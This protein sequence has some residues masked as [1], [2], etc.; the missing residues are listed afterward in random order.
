MDDAVQPCL[1]PDH[2]G[3]PCELSMVSMGLVDRPDDQEILRLAAASVPVLTPC[4]VE[5]CYL[6]RGGRLVHATEDRPDDVVDLSGA[7]SVLAGEQGPVALSGRRWGWAYALCCPRGNVGYLVVSAA[8]EPAAEHRFTLARLAEETGAALSRAASYRRERARAGRLRTSNAELAELNDRLHE[9]VVELEQQRKMLVTL[10][11]VAAAGAG[12]SGIAAALH[13][14]TGHAVAVEDQFGNPLAW[15]GPDRP[16]PYPRRSPRRRAEL[17]AEAGRMSGP[18]R[19]QDR[20]IALVRSYDGVLGVLALVDPERR[21][22]RQQI[23]ALEHAAAV[24]AIELAHQRDLAEAELRHRGDLIGDLL[25]GAQTESALSRAAA[26]GHD[27]HGPHQVLVLRWPA[28]DEQSVVLAVER[29][30]RLSDVDALVARRSGVVVMVAARPASWGRQNHWSEFHHAL[31]ELRPSTRGCIG[32]GGV[33]E[34]PS[35]LPRSYSEALHALAI[36]ERAQDGGVTSFDELGVLRLLFTGEDDSEVDRFVRDWLGVLIDYDGTK[37]AELVATLSQYFDSGGNYDL[38]AA[39]LQIHRSTLRYRL[40]RIRELTSFDL[41][42][43][44][45]RLNLQVA[46][47][48]WQILQPPS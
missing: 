41:G 33:R 1:L 32:A 27:L 14:M 48:A 12:E 44:D 5:A 28:R 6:V 19:D 16:E 29:A 11:A 35:Q 9:A 10:T 40:K 38:T 25:T 45:C 8:A 31:S 34:S 47:R 17:L 4:E 42:A 18:L 39:A 22:G 43:V 2:I 30:A 26:L 7:L 36:R 20:L 3:N 46:T 15:A 23:V 21:A 37:G 24:L 13:A